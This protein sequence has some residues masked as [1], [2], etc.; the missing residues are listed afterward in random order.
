MGNLGHSFAVEL[1]RISDHFEN[2]LQVQADEIRARESMAQAEI[3]RLRLALQALSKSHPSEV[4]QVVEATDVEIEEIVRSAQDQVEALKRRVEAEKKVRLETEAAVASMIGPIEEENAKTQ[5]LLGHK[6]QQLAQAKLVAETR[7]SQYQSLLRDLA[8]KESVISELVSRHPDE[9]KVL[10]KHACK[11]ADQLDYLESEVCAMRQV[12]D[13][14][15]FEREELQRILDVK[16]R[17]LEQTRKEMARF[18]GSPSS[19]LTRAAAEASSERIR[20]MEERVA[21]LRQQLQEATTAHDDV[22]RQLEEK[23][24]ESL[25]LVET[26]AARDAQIAKLDSSMHIKEK[27]SRQNAEKLQTS[28]DRE[29]RRAEKT[30]IE[31]RIAMDQ[32]SRLKDELAKRDAE[33]LSAEGRL[34][35]EAKLTEAAEAKLAVLTEELE[36]A[37]EHIQKLIKQTIAKDH[38]LVEMERRLR[39]NEVKRQANYLTE[40]ARTKQHQFI[41]KQP[42]RRRH[43]ETDDDEDILIMSDGGTPSDIKKMRPETAKDLRRH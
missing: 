43:N 15:A 8:E 42:R 27:L 31:L 40:M 25:A 23:R 21:Q 37:Q 10:E 32:Q 9:A 11:T 2:L 18:I 22:H 34:F 35:R 24:K 30:E 1:K 26:L 6:D 39:S 14:L 3:N 36:E 20:Q 16:D 13:E 41:T 28:L 4:V 29:R 7:Q 5:H 19:E 17:Q 38:Y 33:L 12:I